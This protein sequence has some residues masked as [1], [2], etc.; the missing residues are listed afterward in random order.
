MIELS[1]A[2]ID[3]LKELATV[4]S[5]FRTDIVIIGAVA[6]S[7]FTSIATPEM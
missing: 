5:E 7:A 4:G 2:Q 1:P 6:Y 3:D